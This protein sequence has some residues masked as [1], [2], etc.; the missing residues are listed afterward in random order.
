[1]NLEVLLAPLVRLHRLIQFHLVILLD[2]PGQFHLSPL[3]C[4]YLPLDQDHLFL[5]YRLLDR[6]LPF[7]RD[8]LYHPL[9][10]LF[11]RHHS[12]LCF[13]HSKHKGFHLLYNNLHHYRSDAFFQVHLMNYMFHG[14]LFQFR[15][16]LLGR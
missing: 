12:M 9:G 10:L 6:V 5:L 7:L 8:H 13:L 1:M 14:Y 2:L 16:D 15:L 3:D 11:S 4:L